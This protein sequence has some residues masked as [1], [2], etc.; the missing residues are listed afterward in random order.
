MA[1]ILFIDTTLHGVNAIEKARKRGHEVTFVCGRSMG[2][3]AILGHPSSIM[4][5]IK[6]VVNR[7]IEAD[8]L[9][10]EILMQQ[11]EEVH[12]LSRFD[13]V[14]TTS[15]PAVVPAA[16]LAA[17]FGCLGLGAEAVKIAVYKNLCREALDA[18][19]VRSTKFLASDLNGLKS[20][21]ASFPFP[22]V[23]KPVR[24]MGKLLTS[25]CASRADLAAL[26]ARLSHDR[27]NSV[28]PIRTLVSTTYVVEAY[29]PGQLVSAEVAWHEGK[30]YPMTLTKRQR[31]AT[32]ELV[33]VAALM[34]SGL[35]Y[36]TS[37]FEYVHR[38]LKAVGVQTGL[39]HIEL[40]HGKDGPILVEINARMMGSISP[41]MYEFVFGVNPFD[42]LID[43]HL[44][45]PPT[46]QV[47]LSDRAAI[48]LAVGAAVDG[49]TPIGV[50]QKLVEY[51]QKFPVLISNLN[52]PEGQDIRPQKDNISAFGQIV[53]T[54]SSPAAVEQLGTEFLSGLE[55][56]IQV[57]VHKF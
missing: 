1:H 57:P 7:F 8:M 29:V 37:V 52:V 22:I 17:H 51:L 43:L 19:G 36:A 35:P 6:E 42:L 44:G 38:V 53:L 26:T 13:A 45:Q 49:R 4:Q 28:A 31:S 12:L 55:K 3:L 46:E 48:T 40:I 41:A 39:F 25:I 9:D 50:R 20:V 32:N 21:P 10:S 54:G 11:L 16:K 27:E 5:R 23:V 2:F 14:I 56:L 15:D 24:G 34:P 30:L 33:E 18:A 47:A